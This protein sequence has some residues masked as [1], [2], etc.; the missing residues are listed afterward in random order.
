[1]P[2]SWPSK[3]DTLIGTMFGLDTRRQL[4]LVFGLAMVQSLLLSQSLHG[5]LRH[6]LLLVAIL[7]KKS[8]NEVWS[9]I[10]ESRIF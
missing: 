4:C 1:M 3:G 6:T 10:V 7:L 5:M 2:D 8:E 9:G